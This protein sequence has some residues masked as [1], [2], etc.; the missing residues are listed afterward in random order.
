[1]PQ[2]VI[3]LHARNEQIAA[4]IRLAFESLR[5]E[6]DVPS[7][8]PP[9]VIREAE[10]IVGAVEASSP[11]S[12]WPTHD[13]GTLEYE[14][15]TIDP[16]GSM[17]LDQAVHIARTD[18]GFVVRYAIADVGSFVQP[19]SAIDHEARQRGTTLYAP[20]GRTPLHP[21]VLSEGA[22]SLLPG[23][24]RPAAVW[25]LE[26]DSTGELVN[27]T[28]RRGLV[29]SRARFSYIE[30][31]E[32]L[33]ELAES[34]STGTDTRVGLD[35]IVL[36][37][38]VGPLRLERERAR[39][40]VSLNIPEQEVFENEQGVFELAFRNVLAVENFNA[41]I[42]LLTGIAAGRLML[43]GGVGVLRTLPQADPRDVKRLR[44]TAQA[45]GL[46]WRQEVS[47]GDF[48]DTLDPSR[49]ADAA[50][51][52]EAATLFRGADYLAFSLDPR[53]ASLTTE[54]AL[55]LASNAE[56]AASPGGQH[57][58]I[59]AHYAHITAPLRRLGDRFTTEICLAISAGREIPEWVLAVLPDIP[60]WLNNAGRRGN[61]YGRSTT[62]IVEAAM[63][64]DRINEVFSGVIVEVDDRKDRRGD[65]VISDP[66]VHAQVNGFESLPIGE[67]VEVTLVQ[68]DVATR[69]IKF[70]YGTPQDSPASEQHNDSARQ[71]ST[72]TRQNGTNNRNTNEAPQNNGST[73]TH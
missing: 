21:P 11:E 16:E 23:K 65:V 53:Q 36:L 49:P 73:Q 56:I 17:D 35:T 69:K 42:S 27:T 3:S 57:N 54:A 31:Q 25:T 46:D 45:L 26:L 55:E 13:A 34:G 37:G 15:I 62:D 63:L 72:P 41:Q 20:D 4:T 1:M 51:Q 39:G 67:R 47:Y 10:S 5:E 61:S 6:M 48:L 7:D 60:G 19:D 33:D 2:R 59:G 28:V 8:F 50:F 68:A 18:S 32:I 44:R 71:G 52:H 66:A 12:T 14:F 70:Q 29:E 64:A 22:A 43:E 9:E 58:A 40:G 30:A 24:V 38:V